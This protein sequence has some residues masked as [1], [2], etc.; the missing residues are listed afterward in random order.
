MRWEFRLD[1]VY[2]DIC[3]INM[4]FFASFIWK[5]NLMYVLRAE[6]HVHSPR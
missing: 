5:P 4:Q 2:H 1:M 6:S 3:N